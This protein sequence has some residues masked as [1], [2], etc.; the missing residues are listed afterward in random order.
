VD[1]AAERTA[2]FGNR[3]KNRADRWR[4]RHASWT[5]D[6]VTGQFHLTAVLA[7]G[8]A[9]FAGISLAFSFE[10]I[11]PHIRYNSYQRNSQ[12]ADHANQ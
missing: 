8:F 6:G 9:T 1:R 11:C 10:L 7:A 12:G 2:N 3:F 4:K 5:M